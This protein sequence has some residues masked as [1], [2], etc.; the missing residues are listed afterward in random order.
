[1]SRQ[2]IFEDQTTMANA[3]DTQHPCRT[4][5]TSDEARQY[6]KAPLPGER[7]NPMMET[8]HVDRPRRGHGY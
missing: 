1:M 7:K 2:T 5:Q 4:D 8:Q 6:R 3:L